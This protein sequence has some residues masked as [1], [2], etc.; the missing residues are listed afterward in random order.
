MKEKEV[1]KSRKVSSDLK[2]T[3]SEVKKNEEV[4]LDL[5]DTKSV[6][7][8]KE[9]L[10]NLISIVKLEAEYEELMAK[11]MMMI[12]N[13]YRAA[14]ALNTYQNG[15]GKNGVEKSNEVVKDGK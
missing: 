13:Q 1:K 11:K 9:H 8:Y 12:V 14:D 5:E 4:S 6:V 15:V 2:D 7:K 3:K 10:R